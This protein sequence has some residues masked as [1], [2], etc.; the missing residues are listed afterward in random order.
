MNYCWPIF[1]V[2]GATVLPSV[3]LGIEGC[4]VGIRLDYGFAPGSFE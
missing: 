1:V 3:A 4:T 2:S